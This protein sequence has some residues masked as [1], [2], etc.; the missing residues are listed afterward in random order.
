MKSEKMWLVVTAVC[1]TVGVAWGFDV[2]QGRWIQQGILVVAG[3][4]IG[5][6]LNNIFNGSDE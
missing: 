1:A 5:L 6:L 3:V 2:E 4:Q